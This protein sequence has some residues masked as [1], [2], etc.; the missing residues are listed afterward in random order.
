M[1]LTDESCFESGFTVAQHVRTA[2]RN[3]VV[4]QVRN[5]DWVSLYEFT[6]SSVECRFLEIVIICYEIG[7]GKMSQ[8]ILGPGLDVALEP[9]YIRIT[10]HRC[11]NDF[12]DIIPSA[13]I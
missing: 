8:L 9:H 3:H 4:F 1:H 6:I 13:N 7:S 11:P 12:W 5:P 10:N 2:M